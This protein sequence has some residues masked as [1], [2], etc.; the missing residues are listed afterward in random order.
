MAMTGPVRPDPMTRAI[1]GLTGISV[2][3]M[4]D[5][6]SGEAGGRVVAKDVE[7]EYLSLG[8][9]CFL[10]RWVEYIGALDSTIPR[11]RL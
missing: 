10:D 2:V 11:D 4:V 1:G 6:C 5:R 9:L 3:A 7:W 8:K